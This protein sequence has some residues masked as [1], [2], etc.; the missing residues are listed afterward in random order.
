ME[1]MIERYEYIRGGAPQLD[2]A[3]RNLESVLSERVNTGTEETICD[4]RG[5]PSILFD[6][7]EKRWH[8]VQLV[9]LV[10][11]VESIA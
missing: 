3:L 5:G 2:D 4:P 10:T 6:P 11:W 7:I 9:H 8:A 1:R